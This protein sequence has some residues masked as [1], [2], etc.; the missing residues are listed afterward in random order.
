MKKGL[1]GLLQ[2]DL[3]KVKTTGDFPV[4][5]ILPDDAKRVQSSYTYE[6]EVLAFIPAPTPG[7]DKDPD[8]DSPSNDDEVK[9]R[10][11]LILVIIAVAVVL[12]AIVGFVCLKTKK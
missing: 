4:I 3:G 9:V 7:D 1:Q 6:K 10:P 5:W 12:T 8:Q 2:F 11:V